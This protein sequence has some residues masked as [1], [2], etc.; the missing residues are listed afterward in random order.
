M[1]VTIDIGAAE[2]VHP[3][4]KRAVG[5]RLALQARALVYGEPVESSGPIAR[6]MTEEGAAVRVWFDHT[7]GLHVADG[8]LEGF[9]LAGEDGHFFPADAVIEEDTVRVVSSSV[10]TPTAVRYGW[11]AD[12]HSKLYN[13]AQLPASPFVLTHP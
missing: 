12:P 4:N 13:G 2:D 8:K 10:R 5:L 6:Q 11:E 7:K 1:V 3:T 9:E